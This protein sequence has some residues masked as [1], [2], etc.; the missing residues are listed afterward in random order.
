[1]STILSLT[2]L[3]LSKKKANVTKQIEIL[4]L[5]GRK[6]GLMG[7]YDMS[8]R[9]ENRTEI[10]QPST[11]GLYIR[12]VGDKIDNTTDIEQLKASI[13]R[14]MTEPEKNAADNAMKCLAQS[15]AP[16]NYLSFLD[17]YAN[18]VHAISELFQIPQ[19]QLNA[20]DEASDKVHCLMFLGEREF[21][22]DGTTQTTGNNAVLTIHNDMTGF[23]GFP[24][25]ICKIA[26]SEKKGHPFYGEFDRGFLALFND[27]ESVIVASIIESVVHFTFFFKISK[28]QGYQFHSK[29]QQEECWAYLVTENGKEPTFPLELWKEHLPNPDRNAT[30]TQYLQGGESI[31][32]GTTVKYFGMNLP[33][34]SAMELQHALD[35]AAPFRML[36]IK[37]VNLSVPHTHFLI[38]RGAGHEGFRETKETIKEMV[39]DETAIEFEG[40][41]FR[42]RLWTKV[43]N[44]INRTPEPSESSDLTWK[45]GV[46]FLMRYGFSYD[47]IPIETAL[48]LAPQLEPISK[49]FNVYAS[50]DAVPTE[51]FRQIRKP[52]RELNTGPLTTRIYEAVMLTVENNPRIKAIIEERTASLLGGTGLDSLVLDFNEFEEGDLVKGEV[53]KSTGGQEIDENGV[54]VQVERRRTEY[55]EGEESDE[56]P[57][58]FSNWLTRTPEFHVPKIKVIRVNEKEVPSVTFVLV[59]KTFSGQDVVGTGYKINVSCEDSLHKLD[60]RLPQISVRSKFGRL[61]TTPIT[62]V[63]K[64]PRNG[65]VAEQSR[66]PLHW[67]FDWPDGHS[68]TRKIEIIV[69]R[70][71]KSRA[72]KPGVVRAKKISN[73]QHPITQQTVRARQKSTLPAYKVLSSNPEKEATPTE[74]LFGHESMKDF[75]G[76]KGNDTFIMYDSGIVY[77]VVSNPVVR[78]RLEQVATQLISTFPTVNSEDVKQRTKMF[79]LRDVIA[80]CHRIG[81]NISTSGLEGENQKSLF[82]QESE[83]EWMEILGALYDRVLSYY[84][85]KINRLKKN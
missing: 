58:P 34:K 26:P 42:I 40:R 18:P 70:K 47:E 10:I 78:K 54:P 27:C 22:K 31:H 41:T 24:D 5:E 25:T 52:N 8:Q 50:L 77:P 13:A 20:V 44:F 37:V 49:F 66:I 15:V 32:D 11:F 21:E 36:P 84:F 75:M 23:G 71:Q 29:F 55:T 16:N 60:G 38:R 72:R 1:M 56:Q 53:G 30:R 9:V 12:L 19:Y 67:R 83:K 4:T 2:K 68:E 61:K 51:V 14:E 85:R 57:A 79:Y 59:A 45:K 33:L 74:E 6:L 65:I 64:L 80:H 28:T 46:V 7:K 63:P 76:F 17:N 43:F 39:E 35:F 48:K 73:K 69:K 3:G 62:V 82:S 81:K